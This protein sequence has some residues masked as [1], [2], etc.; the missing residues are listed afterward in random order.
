ML[1]LVQINKRLWCW[2]AVWA[3]LKFPIYKKQYTVLR[4]P[5]TPSVRL[6][7]YLNPRHH[8]MYLQLLQ[9]CAF[10]ETILELPSG[11]KVCWCYE[12]HCTSGW[13][14]LSSTGQRWSSRQTV[15]L[16]YISRVRHWRTHIVRLT[17]GTSQ[18]EGV[19]CWVYELS[20]AEGT[21]EK[22]WC[23][24]APCWSFATLNENTKL[25]GQE[26]QDIAWHICWC[27][28]ARDMGSSSQ[29]GFPTYA[30]LSNANNCRTC[31]SFPKLPQLFTTN[32]V[33]S[34]LR[35]FGSLPCFITDV[36]V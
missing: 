10:L 19:S 21:G 28:H 6:L 4:T 36:L 14:T 20:Q 29:S 5:K 22:D 11:C 24:A 15:H 8:H 33:S 17:L 18:L 16:L 34:S 31:A 30:V 7:K 27:S 1:L 12:R 2:S 13:T 26:I 32:L 3:K 23:S 9:P 25:I 35:L